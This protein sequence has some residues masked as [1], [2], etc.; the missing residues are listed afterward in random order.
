MALFVPMTAG[1]HGIT[2]NIQLEG[3]AFWH[4]LYAA[5]GGELAKSGTSAEVHQFD[6]GKPDKLH[7]DVNTW[8]FVLANPH[9]SPVRFTIGITWEQNG[10]VIA[11]WPPN[12]PKKGMI[13]AGEN[14]VVD[15]SAFLAVMPKAEE[16][17]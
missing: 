10:K 8:H 3:N 2:A 7:L 9:K 4:F 6:L 13:K 5:D 16:D 14:T 11:R 15:D 17:E 12:G 1:E